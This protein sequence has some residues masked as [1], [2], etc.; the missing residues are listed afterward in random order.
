MRLDE[1]IGRRS[2]KR[3][4]SS[5]RIVPPRRYIDDRFMGEAGIR[6]GWLNGRSRVSVVSAVV[7]PGEL[8]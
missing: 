3:R 6:T 1:A 5:G 2:G 7:A 4:I 8:K